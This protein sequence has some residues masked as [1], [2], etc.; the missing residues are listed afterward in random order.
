MASM[1]LAQLKLRLGAL[2]LLLISATA[3]LAFLAASRLESLAASMNT[4]FKDR[5]VCLQQLHAV[6]D[7]YGRRIPEAIAAYRDGRLGAAAAAAD[8][9][10]AH[11]RAVGEWQ[12]YLQTYLTPQEARLASSAKGLLGEAEGRASQARELIEANERPGLE[13]LLAR[14]SLSPARPLVDVMEQLIALQVD[15]AREEN[16]R[17][18]ASYRQTVWMLALLAGAAVALGSLLTWQVLRSHASETAS[19]EQRLVRLNSFYAALSQANQLLVKE[20]DEATLLNEVCR[21]AVETGQADFAC[22]HVLGEASVRRVAAAGKPQAFYD[23]FPDSWDP[24]AEDVQG[25]LVSQ[26]LRDGHFVVRQD[27]GVASPSDRWAQQMLGHGIRSAAGFALR[28]GGRVF[29]TLCLYA[30]EAN[31]FDDPLVRLVNEIAA[32]ISFGLDNVDRRA[33][34]A[35]AAGARAA[36]LRAELSNQ[37]KTAFLSRMS[38]ELRTPL[39][40]M[41]G[42]TQLIQNDARERLQASDAER[43]DLVRQAGWHLLSLVNDVL[44]VSRIEAGSFDMRVSALALAPLLEDALQISEP[45]AKQSGV[46]MGAAF[47]NTGTVHVLADPVRLRQVLINLLSNAI[48]YNRPGGTVH[49]QLELRPE[50]VVVAVVDSGLGMSAEQLEHLYEPFNR[51][52][53][54]RGGIDGTGLGLALTRQLV[55]LMGGEL[56]VDSRI[57]VGTTVSVSL[58]RAQAPA[59]VAVAEPAAEAVTGAASPVSGLVLYIEDNEV[60]VMLVEQMLLACPGVRFVH[61]VDGQSGLAKAKALQPDLILLDMSMPD[62]SGLD[63]LAR[64]RQDPATQGLRVVVLSASAMQADIDSACAA[65]ALDYWTKPLDLARFLENLGKTLKAG[66]AQRASPNGALS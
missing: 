32:D 66:V 43:L 34:M 57:G 53:R 46:T 17:S 38:H 20:S 60:N 3:A 8:L 28:R 64:L 5:V 42:F 27:Y 1:A 47:R 36:Q 19:H 55:G 40:A 51:L 31:F 25:A 61:A 24:A 29:G 62:M 10:A 12:A 23:S 65:G 11:Q 45:L 50:S 39:N 41:L 59:A 26:V 37:A 44:D 33:D 21:I 14:Q 52:G 9:A 35:E 30:Y 48:K 4:V 54:E 18:S 16:A 22:I 7:A 13:R 49:V 2:V 58:Q 15:V 63:V 56:Q 6:E